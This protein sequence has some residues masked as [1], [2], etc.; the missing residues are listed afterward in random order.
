VL[1]RDEKRA[2][3]SAEKKSGKPWLVGISL[4]VS[5]LALAGWFLTS[6]G[7]GQGSGKGSD[8]IAAGGTI[9]IPL[10]QLSDGQAHFFSHQGADTTI[11]FFAVKGG[12][13]KLRTAFDTC[14]VC[15]KA[16]K[17]YRFEGGEAVCNNCGM[18]FAVDKI[19][20]IKGGCNPSPLT[21][22]ISGDRVEIAVADLEKGAWYFK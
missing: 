7:A 17:G 16:K 15:Y 20:E 5:L 13:G 9:S 21:A 4:T 14:D 6:H 19:G 3:F 12:D 22:S 1:E 18:K 10:A 11:R 8:V 2:H